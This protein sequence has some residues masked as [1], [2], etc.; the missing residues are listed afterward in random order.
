[1]KAEKD[2][3]SHAEVSYENPST[4]PGQ[5]CGNCEHFIPATANAPAACEGVQKPIQITAWCKRFEKESQGNEFANA[6]YKMAHGKK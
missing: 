5:R 1:M 6:P 4:H 3:Y 2:K